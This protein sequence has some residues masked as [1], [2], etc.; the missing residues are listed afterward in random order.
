MADW[1]QGAPGTSSVVPG[2]AADGCDRI[3][4]KLKLDLPYVTDQS[5]GQVRWSYRSSHGMLHHKTLL[6]S[7]AGMPER[8]LL[9]SFNWSTHGTQAY[10]NTMLLSREPETDA[11]LGAFASEFDGLWHDPRIT[12][13]PDVAAR[14][15][16]IA[17]KKVQAG[18]SM[19]D[20]VDLH[21]ILETP[22]PPETPRG[23]IRIENGRILPAFAGRHLTSLT[24]HYGF[25]PLNNQRNMQLLRP[26]GARKPAPLSVN[27]VALEA[28][29]SIPPGDPIKVAMYAMS[30][31]V[32]EFGALLEAARRGCPVDILLDRKIGAEL[33][34]DLTLRPKTENLP[35]EVR[36][37]RRRMH[38]KYIVAPRNGVV[39]T[40]T[41]NMTIDSAQRHAEHRI[42][43][44]DDAALSARFAQDFETIWQRL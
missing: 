36:T 28:I 23:N 14:L 16:I 43:F 12:A 10:E 30:P 18:G 9:G 8:L 22:A 2:L 31:R 35:I 42:L 44:R 15:A 19:H 39:V 20:L 3:A 40:G 27:A 37:T 33:A 13:H 24:A 34:R 41:A 7:V 32:P 25:S 26:S 4:V 11:V 1:S 6:I 38:Q 21:E 17:R 29:R 5:T